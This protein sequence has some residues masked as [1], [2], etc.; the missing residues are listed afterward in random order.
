MIKING[1]EIED[2]FTEYGFGWDDPRG[3]VR[4]LAADEADATKTISPNGASDGRKP[5]V[6]PSASSPRMKRMP[7]SKLI[8]QVEASSSVRSFRPRGPKRLIAL[9]LWRPLYD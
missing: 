4:I 9:K 3:P 6:T 7:G 8:T 2:H 5:T 1:L